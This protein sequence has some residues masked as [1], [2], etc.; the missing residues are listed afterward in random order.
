[1]PIYYKMVAFEDNAVAPGAWK[2]FT[3]AEVNGWDG[4]NI[5]IWDHLNGVAAAEGQQHAELNAHPYTGS[6]FSIY[7][8]FPTVL[9]QTY[10]VSFFYRGRG[11]NNESFNFSVGNLSQLMD[12][13]VTTGWAHYSN[14]FVAN[15]LLT[16][17]RFTTSTNSTTG[18]FL[19]GVAVTAHL[20]VSEP[21]PLA[22]LVLGGVALGL[23]RRRRV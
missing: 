9:S 16:T 6:V 15:N 18:N 17:I 19:D 2:Y 11:S 20:V 5:E 1:M 23:V 14:S 10:D 4:S 8:T 7:Q 3:A 13:H 22:L 21:A 12:D